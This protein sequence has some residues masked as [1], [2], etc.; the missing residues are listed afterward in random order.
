M[1]RRMGE[2]RV[3]EAAVQYFAGPGPA[4]R[5][6]GYQY[7]PG[8]SLA[9]AATAERESSVDVILEGR[10]RQALT[11][12]N[13]RLSPEARDAAARQVL[14][15]NSPSLEENNLAFQRMLARGVTVEVR[16]ASGIRGE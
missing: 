10:F 7:L 1:S 14:H 5:G 9:P 2:W 4:L 16:T 8:A 3:E 6:L 12:I 13:P 11:R 15:L